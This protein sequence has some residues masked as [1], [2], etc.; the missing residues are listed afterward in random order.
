M[1]NFTFAGF[2]DVKPIVSIA[3]LLMI[4]SLLVRI[5]IEYF[6]IKRL[7]AINQNLDFNIFKERMIRYYKNRVNTHYIVTPIIIALYTLGF[8][9]LLPFFKLALS[10]FFYSYIVLS[11]IIIL[12]IGVFLIGKQIQKE[13]L[14]PRGLT[15]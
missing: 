8:I 7:K 2:G 4:S 3:L 5:G 1:H 9:I 10:N 12:V 14:I 11:A 13:L 6:S 15:D